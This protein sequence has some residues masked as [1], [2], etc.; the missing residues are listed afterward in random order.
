M[1]TIKTV[2]EIIEYTNY[3]NPPYRERA[4]KNRRFYPL[5]C[6]LI[7][8]FTGQINVFTNPWDTWVLELLIFVIYP[9]AIACSQICNTSLN[10]I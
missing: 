5:D 6:F 3:S 2:N 4:G 10:Y 9:P 7:G 8:H 1:I